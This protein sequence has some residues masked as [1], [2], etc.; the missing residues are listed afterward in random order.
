V[1]DFKSEWPRSN[2]NRWPTSFRN[3]WPACSGISITNP[4]FNRADAFLPHA[5]ELGIEYVAFLHKADWLNAAE[6]G[7]LIES[8]WCPA[9]C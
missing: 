4:P 3:Q 6:R 2:R 1:A 8:V 7:C 5:V 9:R